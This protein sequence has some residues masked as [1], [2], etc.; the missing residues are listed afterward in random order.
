MNKLES[1]VKELIKVGFLALC[2]KKINKKNLILRKRSLKIHTVI[3]IYT[4]RDKLK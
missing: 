3:E 1:L 2:V 4:Q